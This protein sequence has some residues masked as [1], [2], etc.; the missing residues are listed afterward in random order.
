MNTQT[1]PTRRI[2]QAVL[3]IEQG[4]VATDSPILK[5]KLNNAMATAIGTLDGGLIQQLFEALKDVD[6]ETKKNCWGN[7]DIEPSV[8]CYAMLAYSEIVEFLRYVDEKLDIDEEITRLAEG[9]SKNYDGEDSGAE[10]YCALES[11]IEKLE[12]LAKAFPPL[13]DEPVKKGI[14][15]L[16]ELNRFL[17]Y[18]IEE[19]IALNALLFDTPTPLRAIL[20]KAAIVSSKSGSKIFVANILTNAGEIADA[21]ITIMSLFIFNCMQVQVCHNA[22]IDFL[23][24]HAK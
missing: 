16:K 10:V 7:H 3:L 9:S 20:G 15:S 23:Q 17:N 18:K 1:E 6:Y 8:H 14:E 24:K 4:Y 11:S 12:A 19:E 5:R 21:L 2:V 22:I 13:N